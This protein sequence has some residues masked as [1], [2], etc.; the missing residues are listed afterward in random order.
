MFDARERWVLADSSLLQA[1][2]ANEPVVRGPRGGRLRSILVLADRVA[3]AGPVLLAVG[4]VD[5]ITKMRR[6]RL[7]QCTNDRLC[8][9][10]VGFGAGSEEALF[11]QYCHESRDSVARTSQIDVATMGRIHRVGVAQAL[12]KLWTA[13]KTVLVT[14][15]RLPDPLRNR[16]I[17]FLK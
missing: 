12:R 15:G 10:F 2:A 6:Q 17:D 1:I 7:H 14:V 9:L 16:R 3:L 11:A 13:C 8:R 4:F 5:L